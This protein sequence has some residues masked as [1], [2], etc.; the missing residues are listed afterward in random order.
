MPVYHSSFNEF[1]G[2]NICGTAIFPLKTKVKGPAPPA[3]TGDVDI[4]DEAITF[5]RANVM[6]RNFPPQGPGDLALGYIT[7]YIAQ[8]LREFS[9]QKTKN[10]AKAKITATSMSQNFAIPGDKAFALAGFFKEPQNRN[11]ADMFR[12]YF[13][14]I[15]EEVVNR[16]V[17]LAYLENGTQN[18]WWIS[19]SKRKFMNIA[20]V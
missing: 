16:V 7:A 12:Q 4:I 3:K 11:E 1:K 13:R 20:S 6:F 15:R 17:E 10:E 9:A 8:I 14:Q 18:K 5:F 19:F 2:Q